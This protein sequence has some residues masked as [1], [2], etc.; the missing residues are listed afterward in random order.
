MDKKYI[1]SFAEALEAMKDGWAVKRIC[2][3]GYWEI[4]HV[5]KMKDGVASDFYGIVMHNKDGSIVYM[6]DG[7]K[8]VF[9]A[10]NM[11]ESDWMVLDE[12]QRAEL[13][14]V[15]A[16]GFCKQI[17]SDWPCGFEVK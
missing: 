13:D 4:R 8:S 7:C 12:K 11:A 2:W 3:L 14:K 10:E 6:D 15:I 5:A 9:T 17:S 1:V 16:T